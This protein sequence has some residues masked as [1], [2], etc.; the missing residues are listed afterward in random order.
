MTSSSRRRWDPAV[1]QDSEG[2][3]GTSVDYWPSRGTSTSAGLTGLG[4]A[5]VGVT[6]WLAALLTGNVTAG[7]LPWVAGL[8][9]PLL[10]QLANGPAASVTVSMTL[11]PIADA[12]GYNSPILARII[13]GT[14]DAVTLPGPRRS[15]RDVR[16]W[17]RRTRDDVQGRRRRHHPDI[18]RRGR[19]EHRPGAGATRGT[20]QI[21]LQAL[22]GAGAL[23]R[24][25]PMALS[26]QG[27]LVFAGGCEDGVPRSV[28]VLT[29]SLARVPV[30]APDPPWARAGAGSG[31]HPDRGDPARAPC[32]AGR[33]CSAACFAT[34]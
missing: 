14:A 9:T 24:V 18:D 15:G 2:L 34:R 21:P 5:R 10:T 23:H 32:A 16:V 11:F 25:R 3:D 20:D 17:R 1:A 6:D 27:R 26:I 8:A 7:A 19:A 31:A 13:A 28:R 4:L 29:P 12:A 30:R 22:Q 33:S